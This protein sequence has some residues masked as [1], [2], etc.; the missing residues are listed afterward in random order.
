MG[1]GI[2]TEIF[3][4]KVRRP[5]DMVN[6]VE[7]E[8]YVLEILESRVNDFIAEHE[9]TPQDI[10]G[11]KVKLKKKEEIVKRDSKLGKPITEKVEFMNGKIYLSYLCKDTMGE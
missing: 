7:F 6:N 8:Y 9:L 1:F 4:K 11:Y 3:A 10:V 2:T 5:A